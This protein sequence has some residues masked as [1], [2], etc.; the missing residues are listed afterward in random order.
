M[1]KVRYLK[2]APIVEAIIDI[3]ARLPS[4]FDIE[5]A[6][7][8]LKKVI[9][10]KYTKIEKGIIASIKI[11]R[12][13]PDIKKGEEGKIKAFKF[14]SQDKKEVAQF[15]IDGFTY[16]RLQPYTKWEVVV[17]EAKKLW[18]LYKSIVIGL[19]I[20]R[21][22]VQYI[23]RI[24]IPT[25]HELEEYFTST[26]I[27]PKK[28]PQIFTNFFSSLEFKE[29]LLFATVVQ[30]GVPS[31]KKNNVG[32]ILDITVRKSNSKGINEKIIWE[33]INKMREL[34]NRI[35]FEMITEKTVG[36]YL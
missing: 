14:T 29:G 16:S 21:L 12:G 1:T 33:D 9:P 28:L 17:K 23:N 20:E 2:R 7:I 35:F 10:K 31:P 30:T 15:R 26:P 34:K 4:D 18:N 32:V 24:D 8:S 11:M 27:L 36:M 19:I 3:R 22:S 13:K 6:I 5:K 25:Q